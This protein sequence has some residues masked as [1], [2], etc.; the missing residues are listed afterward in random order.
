VT[1]KPKQPGT[2][3]RRLR[4]VLKWFLIVALVGTLALIGGFIYLYKTTP[5]PDPNKDF[6]TQT[7][8]VYYADG[9]SQLGSYA[10]GTP[11]SRRRTGPSGPTA[12]STPRASSARRSTTRAVARPRVRPR[13]PSSTSRSCT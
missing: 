7:S 1:R 10:S 13:S 6:Q 2:T 8:F 12:A 4:K 9:K 3:R 5:I 11:S